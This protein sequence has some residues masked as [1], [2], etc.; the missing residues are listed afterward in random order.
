M[1]ISRYVSPWGTIGWIPVFW[2]FDLLCT[3]N[4][5]GEGEGES[6]VPCLTELNAIVQFAHDAVNVVPEGHLV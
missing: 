1:M 3:V 6:L 2:R 4:G 5:G